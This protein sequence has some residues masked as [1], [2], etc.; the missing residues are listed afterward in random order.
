MPGHPLAKRGAPHGP[1]TALRTPHRGLWPPP[2]SLATYWPLTGHPGRPQ[3]A[4]GEAPTGQRDG[5]AYGH[6]GAPAPTSRPPDG[7]GFFAC[8]GGLCVVARVP[9]PPFGDPYTPFPFGA[10][11]YPTGR[12][13]G[14]LWPPT[15]HPTSPTYAPQAPRPPSPHRPG[16]RPPPSRLPP[17]PPRLPPTPPTASL[18]WGKRNPLSYTDLRGGSPNSPNFS[19]F[20]RGIEERIREGG[21]EEK[22]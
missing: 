20:L 18:S 7:E 10:S 21:G 6:T 16:G 12:V 2:P 17:T 14:H 19:Y 15:G 9:D 8:K 1:P 4:K 5:G 11:P 3:L 22:G 13:T